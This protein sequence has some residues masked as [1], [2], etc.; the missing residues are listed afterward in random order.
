VVVVVVVGGG[1]DLY[2]QGNPAENQ[3]PLSWSLIGSRMRASPPL[4][5]SSSILLPTSSHCVYITARENSEMFPKM[6]ISVLFA[7]INM[8]QFE[9]V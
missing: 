5:S 7:L 3:T 8:F 9:T 4:S 6:S 2:I 1:G